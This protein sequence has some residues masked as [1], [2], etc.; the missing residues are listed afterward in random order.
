M[1]KGLFSSLLI[2]SLLTPVVCWAEADELVE[3]TKDD[4]MV[5]AGAG[6]G[7]AVLGLSTLSFYDKPS[8]HLSNI[9]M[10]A[11]IGII[12][13]VVYVAFN[14]AQRSGSETSQVLPSSKDLNST[15]RYAWHV[16][17]QSESSWQSPT[18]AN[19][20]WTKNF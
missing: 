15:E 8:K 4:L 2:L 7:G 13:G 5:V 10:G 18:Y 6:L 3:N 17:N 16:E 9:W 14:Y 20:L 1:M 12:G 11:A 19:S